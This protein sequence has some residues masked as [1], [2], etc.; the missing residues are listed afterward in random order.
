MRSRKRTDAQYGE[1]YAALLCSKRP[2][3]LVTKTGQLALAVLTAGGFRHDVSLR[4]AY[5]DYLRLDIS[6]KDSITHHAS[7]V[8][9]AIDANRANFT[10]SLDDILPVVRSHDYVRGLQDLFQK[11]GIALDL[12]CDEIADPF[13]LLFC[14]HKDENMTLLGSEYLGNA[15]IET[16][17]ALSVNNLRRAFPTAKHLRSEDGLYFVAARGTFESSF[18]VDN[19][20]WREV[21]EQSGGDIIAIAPARGTV[22]F[23]ASDTT[24]I[25]A[26]LR[27]LAKHMYETE[28]HPIADSLLVRQGHVWV[29]ATD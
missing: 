14:Q 16:L 10:L 26:Y 3:F 19:E 1:A 15:K 25:R 13:V 6:L 28:S 11:Q 27:R 8:V 2:D 24:E 22:L 29:T 5:A 23:S 18:L 12:I 9:A 4:D 20:F 21:T 7:A 17:R